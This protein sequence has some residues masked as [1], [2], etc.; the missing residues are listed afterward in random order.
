MKFSGIQSNQA[1]TVALSDAGQAIVVYPELFERTRAGDE[2]MVQVDADELLTVVLDEAVRYVNGDTGISARGKPPHGDLRF[3][4]TAGPSSV[5]GYISNTNTLWQLVASGAEG[6]A[7]GFTGELFHPRPL[8]NSG[9][10]LVNDFYIPQLPP[11][12]ERS[13]ATEA[14]PLELPLQL[15]VPST[16]PSTRAASNEGINENN[17]RLSQSFSSHAIVAGE[18]AAAEVTL[19]NISD[20]W[21]TNLFLEVFFLLEDSTLVS[22]DS[23]CTEQLSAS[24]QKVLR[25][26]L[27]SFA[28]GEQKQLRYSVRPH[29]DSGSTL[30]STILVGAIRNDALIN[31]V[32]D[33]FTDSD[34]DGISDYNERLDG[35]D[36]ADADSVDYATTIIDVLALYTGGAESAFPGGVPT[37]IN[38]LFSVANQIYRDSGVAIN[39]R[40]VHHRRVSYSDEHDMDT[41]LQDLISQSHP[42]FSEVEELRTRFGADLVA[43]FRPLESGGGRCGL[44][45]V[46][47]FRTNGYFAEAAQ[48][49]TVFS[50]VAIDCPVDIALAHELGHNMGLTHSHLQDGYGGT[51]NFATGYGVRGE[52]VTVMAFPEAFNAP[53]R[54]P[55]FS[56]PESECLG[57]P[58]GVSADQSLGADA[59]QALNLVRQQ[60]ASYRRT[61][62]PDLPLVPVASL[63]GNST[64]AT[65]AIAASRDSGFSFSDQFTPQDKVDLSAVITVD[66]RHIGS[67]GSIHVLMGEEGTDTLFQLTPQGELLRWDSRIESLISLAGIRRLNPEERLSLLNRFSFGE[68]L[69]GIRL[70]IYIAYWVP[71]HDE[72]VYTRNPLTLRVVRARP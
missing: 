13:A 69:I 18:V 30:L 33:V 66:E 27:G 40:P 51:F 8:L 28:P 55:R 7:A 19:T 43:L 68:D 15:A 59:V 52:F 9:S 21:H 50:T 2:F 42:A 10:G 49:Q 3:T 41:A 45:P 4:L 29:L 17:F 14:D 48:R 53:S 63:S 37:R 47:G 39:L 25:C 60:I 56:N 72:I 12:T 62:L 44:A 57:F 11:S 32:E 64:E 71:D 20:E 22:A 61:T 70:V 67:P 6:E 16:T 36:P 34:R 1:G 35:T 46:G 23:N 26:E 38:Q 58:C 24:L 65:I 54:V 31:I 5:F